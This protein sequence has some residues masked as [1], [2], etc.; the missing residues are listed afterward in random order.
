[1]IAVTLK[2][3][4]SPNTSLFRRTL[5]HCHNR[6]LATQIRMIKQ[7]RTSSQLFRLL[8]IRFNGRTLHQYVRHV[9]WVGSLPSQ[10]SLSAFCTKKIDGQ[11]VLLHSSLLCHIMSSGSN[12]HSQDWL[13]CCEVKTR[14]CS[15]L[16]L[17]TLNESSRE[18]S[19]FSRG[20]G[21]KSTG[22]PPQ[23][24]SF[25]KTTKGKLKYI[26][27]IWKYST[28]FVTWPNHWFITQKLLSLTLAMFCTVKQASNLPFIPYLCKKALNCADE[29]GG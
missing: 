20:C 15:D 4:N 27:D 25:I 11:G 26:H 18:T 16:F 1:M 2:W 13:G 24:W 8:S 3:K 9:R 10:L 22:M 21:G 14:S 7:Q 12:T 28:S 6:L 23:N 17:A 29:T 19:S 5:W